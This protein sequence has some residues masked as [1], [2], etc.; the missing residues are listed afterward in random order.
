[1]KKRLFAL[2]LSVVMVTGM[3]PVSAMEV[4]AAETDEVVL[5]DN[6]T[7]STYTD[8]TTN[9]DESY[10]YTVT[11]SDGSTQEITVLAEGDE[12]GNSVKEETV[13][14]GGTEYILADGYTSGETY[15][16]V[17]TNNLALKSDG[18]TVSAQTVTIA[19][20]KIVGPLPELEFTVSGPESREYYTVVDKDGNYLVMES[21]AVGLSTDT[22]TV[23]SGE[24]HY[25]WLYN[26]FQLKDSSGY[27]LL[28][29]DGGAKISGQ[30]S[31]F[32]LYT[33]TVTGSGTGETSTVYTVDTTGLDALIAECDKLLQQNYTEESWSDF[34]TALT[35]AKDAK[36][37]LE[38]SYDTED[39]AKAALA[40][41]DNAH[42]ALLAAKKALVQLE[43]ITIRPTWE[44]TLEP[45]NKTYG[46]NGQLL[47]DVEYITNAE[48]KY[49][50][51][52]KEVADTNYSIITWKE[53][54]GDILG[55]TTDPSMT[56]WDYNTDNQY[57]SDRQKVANVSAATWNEHEQSSGDAW[58]YGSVR[59][60]TGTFT[61]PEGYDVD[62]TVVYQSVNDA[63]YSAIYEYINSNEDLKARYGN[64][65]VYPINDDM[66]VFIRK[67]DDELK[68]DNLDY[69][70][71]MLFWSGT[72]G[73][74]LW[75]STNNS[76]DDWGRTTPPT[77][78]SVNALPAYYRIMPNNN[79]TTGTQATS[80]SIDYSKMQHSDGWYTLVNSNTVM[81]TVKKLY[82]V[83]DLS[84]QEMVI[85]IFCFDNSTSGGMDEVEL[86]FQ[87]T[88]ETA[89]S[90]QVNYYLDSVL[91]ANLLGSTVMTGVENNTQITLH[92]GTNVNEL[93]HF[94]FA[95]ATKA[96]TVVSNGEQQAPVP[97]TVDIDKENNIINVVYTSGDATDRVYYFYDFGVENT[98][99]Y[100][101]KEDAVLNQDYTI[102]DVSNT[103]QNIKPSI[104]ADGKKVILSYTPTN[105]LGE[106]AVGTLN[107]EFDG[108]YGTEVKPIV[109]APASN[110]LFEEGFMSQSTTT[111]YADWTKSGTVDATTVSDNEDTV[112]GYTDS[113][114]ASTG[115]SG[116]Y[117]ATVNATTSFT[118][119]LEFQFGGTGF[120]LIGTCGPNTGTIAVRV[121]NSVGA[122]VKN[123]LVDTSFTDTTG[124]VDSGT[125][126]YQVPLLQAKDLPEDTY[127]VTIRG[128]YIVYSG[129]STASTFAL[130][131]TESTGG[132]DAISDLYDLMYGVGMTEDDIDSVEYIN[133]GKLM[134]ASTYAT[135]DGDSTEGADTTTTT[136]PETMVIGIDGFRSYR[137]TDYNKYPEK[138]LGVTYQNILDCVSNGFAAYIET[139]EDG[140]YVVNEYEIS[141]GPQN[142]IYLTSANTDTDST[143]RTAT[144]LAIGQA[145][146]V[147]KQIS[148]RSVDGNEV[149]VKVNGGD[150]QANG[151][152][153]TL[154][155]TTEMYYEVTADANGYITIQVESGFLGIG[156]LKLTSG[157]A[158][159]PAVMS[160]SLTEDDYALVASTMRLYA[161]A[162]DEEET[163][164]FTPEKLE[165]TA[166]VQKNKYTATITT[167]SDV[168]YITVNGEAVTKAK[169]KR[170]SDEKVFTYKV[171]LGNSDTMVIEVVAYDA[172]EAASETVVYE[173]QST[174]N[175]K[176]TNKGGR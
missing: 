91:A 145:N 32:K 74:G 162:P 171:K 153:I 79:D 152:T 66:F 90:V 80:G 121:V 102:T 131:E 37:A 34:E 1:M 55:L 49:D 52:G 122:S 166:K 10:V 15:L 111:D 175:G 41:I 148:L 51:N 27:K 68:A 137:A 50:E 163:P 95:A 67:A 28:L 147:S 129:T 60:F 24:L 33:K 35:A 56:V 3:V 94:R 113:Y 101:P 133:M 53:R 164:V 158:T 132:T 4:N 11:G 167:S 71:H 103:N 61:W 106:M 57:A 105:S 100:T 169:T 117:T 45:A 73:K 93:D 29:E 42:K 99:V 86:I 75:S 104:S 13:T 22:K 19:E 124:V 26:R 149:V 144:A 173:I 87:K 151:K 65:K 127:T 128:A 47:V 172:E 97:Y 40:E 16:L 161:A 160:A 96:G 92:E 25:Y 46:D 159:E 154:K 83:E 6:V 156:N 98:Y 58:R 48:S 120:D 30:A 176:K 64:S 88:P 143:T 134:G 109:I 12:T 81:S 174:Q 150:G 168:D 31:T 72:S 63:N 119:N 142:E 2:L 8:T 18:T 108:S 170:G 126:I 135:T 112:F 138:E 5:A 116:V 141:G 89:T 36:A 110:V 165:V 115:D 17:D 14:V 54:A 62:D 76:N 155:H 44:R 107:I 114:K 140:T 118:D 39:A 70:N 23:R 125:T 20:D 130:D 146:S 84:N 7:G 78:N 77:F 139:K 69:L 59:R 123:Y 85:D 9:A 157:N 43:T 82:G 136:T 21:S 38:E